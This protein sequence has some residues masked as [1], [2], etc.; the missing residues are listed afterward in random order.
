MVV[1]FF[2]LKIEELNIPP[3]FG[4]VSFDKNLVLEGVHS[5]NSCRINPCHHN[6]MCH[7]TWND[8]RYL[9]FILAMLLCI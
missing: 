2:P 4:N 3:L 7:N 8:Y 5:D 1:E 6:G 9:F